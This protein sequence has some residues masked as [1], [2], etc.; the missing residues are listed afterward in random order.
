MYASRIASTEPFPF[1][2]IAGGGALSGGG[3]RII[4]VFT[5]DEDSLLLLFV[6]VMVTSPAL[7]DT[8]DVRR[9]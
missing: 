2:W 3:A 8:T 7:E 5:F 1:V 4:S 9:I 6:F